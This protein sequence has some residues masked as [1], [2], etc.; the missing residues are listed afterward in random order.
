MINPENT[1]IAMAPTQRTIKTQ[2]GAEPC[3]ATMWR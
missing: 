2:F 3:G 1:V